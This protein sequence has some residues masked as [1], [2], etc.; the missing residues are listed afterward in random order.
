MNS[1]P[2][3]IDR[4]TQLFVPIP[5][6]CE[7]RNDYLIIFDQ[8]LEIYITDNIV[9]WI[10]GRIWF[11]SMRSTITNVLTHRANVSNVFDKYRRISASVI[12][13]T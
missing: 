13:K 8:S 11:Y 2:Y 1:H 6:C 10:K 5:P 4:K 7:L 3:F 9:P 12:T